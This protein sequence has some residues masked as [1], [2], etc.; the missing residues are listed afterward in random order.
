MS[1]ERSEVRIGGFGRSIALD[2]H[3]PNLSH[4]ASSNLPAS[5]Y[6]P[7]ESFLKHR[8]FSPFCT[9]FSQPPVFGTRV[10]LRHI[11]WPKLCQTTGASPA[12]E[13]TGSFAA[14]FISTLLEGTSCLDTY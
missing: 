4:L 13:I 5:I 14:W 12:R 11:G 8:R 3:W 9:I 10:A 2:S 1:I 7:T 6:T